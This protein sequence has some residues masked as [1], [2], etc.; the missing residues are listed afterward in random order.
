MPKSII[1]SIPVVALT[2][3]GLTVTGNLPCVQAHAVTCFQNQEKQPPTEVSM[4]LAPNYFTYSKNTLEMARELH[5]TVVLYFWAPWCTSCSSLDQE[6]EEGTEKIPDSVAVLRIDYDK[7]SE[8][9][10]QYN[11][12]TQ[13]T[14]VQLDENGNAV[15]T[16][17]GGNIS[18][19]QRYFK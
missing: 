17:V 3:L 15:S 8:L 13:H 18:D 5:K 14:F 10:K 6:L 1:I 12:I 2:L 9:K 19:F 11:I 7:A 16:W 4:E